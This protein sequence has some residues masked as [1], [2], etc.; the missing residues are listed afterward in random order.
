MSFL[1]IL[2][3]PFSVLYWFIIG[4]R[5]KMYDIGMLKS[6]KFEVPTIVVGNLSVGGTGKTPQIEYLIC[7][8]KDTFNVA[9]LSRGYKRKTTGFVLANS[10]IDVRQIG[11]EPYQYHQKFNDIIV[12]VDEKRVNGINE[13]LRLKN[14]PNVVLLDDAFQHRKLQAGF[15]ILLTSYD[16]LYVDDF[17][18]PSGYLRESR[19]GAKRAQVVIVTKCPQDLSEKEQE[20]IKKK[21]NPKEGQKVFFTTIAYDTTVSDDILEISLDRLKAYKVLLVT[22]IANPKPLESFL[23]SKKIR[24]KHLE[25]PDHYYF[26]KKDIEKIK[27]EF[28]AI[29]SEKKLI[30]TSEKDFVRLKNDLEISHLKIKTR[31][32]NHAIDFDKTIKKYVEQSSTNS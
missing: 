27:M 31:F 4:I 25:Y 19:S 23:K 26:S 9:V 20:S 29:N 7:L 6:T 8:L 11:D 17:M 2:A 15:Y 22:G 14:K 28:D 1:Q 5:N 3:I 18:L 13:L 10:N 12:A 30:L 21:I 24:F 32:I 16:K